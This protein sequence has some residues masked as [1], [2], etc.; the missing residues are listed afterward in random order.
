MIYSLDREHEKQQAI[1][2]FHH[3][4]SK[5]K[6]IEL[7]VKNPKRSINQNS[8]LHLLL[9]AFGVEFGYSLQEVKQY[10]FKELVNPEIFNNGDKGDLVIIQEWRSTADLDSKELTIAIE[11]FLNYS[12]QN[13]YRLPEPT[14]LV[15]IE[16]LEKSIINNKQFL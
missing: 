7:K 2:R 5:G 10:I 9:N 1:T 6:K 12:A 16:E 14:D 3:L 13:G 15:W 8:Y 11:R 4:V